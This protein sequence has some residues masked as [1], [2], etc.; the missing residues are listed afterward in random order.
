MFQSGHPQLKISKKIKGKNC[1]LQIEQ[2]QIETFHDIPLKIELVLADGTKR[3]EELVL[4]D[5]SHDFT[6]KCSKKIVQLNL[7][8]FVQLLFEEK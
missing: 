6:F 1:K 7:D 2:V 5:K 4:N 3:Y 8:P